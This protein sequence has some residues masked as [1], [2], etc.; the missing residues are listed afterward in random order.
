MK[1][2]FM[3]LGV[4]FTLVGLCSLSY[5]VGISSVMGGLTNSGTIVTDGRSRSV[6]QPPKRLCSHKIIDMKTDKN[7]ASLGDTI[8][9]TSKVKNTN[10]IDWYG[11]LEEVIAE[12][13]NDYSDRSKEERTSASLIDYLNYFI[14][15]SENL[16]I[17]ELK[18]YSPTGTRTDGVPNDDGW[19][20]PYGCPGLALDQ[21][22]DLIRKIAKKNKNK[23]K[24]SGYPIGNFTFTPIKNDVWTKNGE[25]N[26]L[27]WQAV[28]K[29]IGQQ[30]ISMKDEGFKHTKRI[31]VTDS[32]GF[33]TWMQ[34]LWTFV[35]LIFGPAITLPWWYDRFKSS[36]SNKNRRKLGR[37]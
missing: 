17:I 15:D 32:T 25:T 21:C 3:I 19:P 4:A 9:L 24:L 36:K 26:I 30:F 23:C 37:Y 33:P 6:S 18:P 1:L 20:K 10:T 22:I 16:E 34:G 31:V 35:L 8:I 7:I 5:F 14:T 11:T 27:Q 2:T 28:P 12:Y 13:L 29:S